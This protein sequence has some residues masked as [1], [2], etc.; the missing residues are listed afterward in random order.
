M[1]IKELYEKIGADYDQACRVMKMDKLIDRYVRKF[2]A[3]DVGDKLAEAGEA[4][5]PV[6]LFEAAHAMKG[7]CANLGFTAIAGAAGEITEEYRPGNNRSLSDEEVKAKLAQ[8][9]ELYA[10]TVDG[11][12]EYVEG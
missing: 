1:T 8:I 11:I 6:R 10:R 12:K 5:D 2:I 7:V 3:S 4:M 9:S